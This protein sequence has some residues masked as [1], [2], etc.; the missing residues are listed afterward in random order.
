MMDSTESA[1]RIL[2]VLAIAKGGEI[3]VSRESLDSIG[4][5]THLDCFQDGPVVVV[6][7]IRSEERGK[8]HK[9][10]LR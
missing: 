2:A 3:R 9:S 4:S 8:P 7:V 5:E 1:M 6:R 10:T